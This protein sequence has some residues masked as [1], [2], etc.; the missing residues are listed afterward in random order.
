MIKRL[1][2]ARQRLW[3]AWMAVQVEFQGRYSLDR[4]QLLDTYSNSL[5][6]WRLVAILLLTPLPSLAISLLKE[7]LPLNPMDAG[8]LNNEAFFVRAWLVVA[9]INGN[10]LLQM[11]QAAPRLKLTTVQIVGFALLAAGIAVVFIF[12]VCALT[13]FPI[14][15]GLLVVAPPDVIMICIRFVYIAGPRWRADPS[16][17]NEAMRQMSVFYC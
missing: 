2:R 8:V 4:L 3:A 15:F 5:S 9:F 1:V 13:V 6:I 10:M 12:L 16:L 7:A 11:G 14:P 17:W